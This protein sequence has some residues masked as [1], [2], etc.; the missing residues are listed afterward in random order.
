MS[1]QNN[2][3][4]DLLAKLQ[5]AGED[6]SAALKGIEQ[7]QEAYWHSLTQEQRLMAFCAVVRRIHRA[8]IV[9]HRSYRGSLYDVFGFGFEAYI[10]AQ[11][12]GYMDI[13]NLEYDTVDECVTVIQEAV[14]QRVPASEYADLIQK[15]FEDKRNAPRNTSNQ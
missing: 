3:A 15:Y 6:L 2:S 1:E 10:Q 12:A 13:H 8:E 9:E 7:E 11:D 14:D 5:E 4:N